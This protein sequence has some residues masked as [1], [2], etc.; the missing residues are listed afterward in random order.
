MKEFS[1]DARREVDELLAEFPNKKSALLMV[2][3]VAE[4]E[5]GCLDDEAID[6]TARTCE[7]SAAHVLGMAT[8]YTHFKRPWHGKHRIMVCGTLMCDIGGAPEAVALIRETLGLAPGERTEDGLFS[9]EK[10]ECLADCNRPAV[11]QI[12]NAHFS[13]QNGDA[14]R[15][16]LDDYLRRE[17]KSAA[18]YAGKR[19]V[20]M[21]T[22]VPF[23]PAK[24]DIPASSQSSLSRTSP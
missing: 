6:L 19:G 14:L 20:P 5:F 11:I 18:D 2:L 15:A 8:F 22:G 17:G 12:D 1:A 23:I 13:N 16:T 10:V 24:Q 21:E 9:L 3:R 4:R 7:V